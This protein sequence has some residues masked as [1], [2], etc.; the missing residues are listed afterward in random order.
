MIMYF[1][2]KM[3]EKNDLNLTHQ[4]KIKIIYIKLFLI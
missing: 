1:I 3:N 4:K 2:T